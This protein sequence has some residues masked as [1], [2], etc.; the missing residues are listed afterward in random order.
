MRNAN[1]LDALF[2]LG[3]EINPTVYSVTEFC[4][5]RTAK[6]HFLSLVLTGPGLIVLGSENDLGVPVCNS[7]TQLFLCPAVKN[8][9]L[10]EQAS[11]GRRCEHVAG[12]LV[13]E[14]GLHDGGVGPQHLLR[15]LPGYFQQ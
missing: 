4:R 12:V 13:L 11:C 5:K 10:H 1:A 2:P 9:S 15:Y 8:L 3:R 6:D 7:S 14:L